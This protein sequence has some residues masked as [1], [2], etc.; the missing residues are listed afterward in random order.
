[1][2]CLRRAPFPHRG[3]VDKRLL[4]F[5]RRP[6]TCMQTEF[7]GTQ[8]IEG[9]ALPEHDKSAVLLCV[10]NDRNVVADCADT[11]ERRP[12]NSST[13][14]SGGWPASCA[15]P[16]VSVRNARNTKHKNLFILMFLKMTIA[17]AAPFSDQF[18]LWRV[19]RRAESTSV[20]F[21]Q[22]MEND[23]WLAPVRYCQIR[24][25]RHQRRI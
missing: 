5:W 13:G 25:F 12:I 6:R 7:R 20:H 14:K 8:I 11:A 22:S 9:I 15:T 18:Q 21:F 19:F 1:M 3:A 16:L 24:Q 23:E 4:L 10:L 17:P 2:S